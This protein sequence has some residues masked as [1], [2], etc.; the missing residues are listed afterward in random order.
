[1][2]W[3]RIMADDTKKND[4]QQVV[5]EKVQSDLNPAQAQLATT[6]LDSNGNI[7]II[8]HQQLRF[9]SHDIRIPLF[10]LSKSGEIRMT[11]KD[12]V[13]IESEVWLDIPNQ[14][15]YVMLSKM[16]GLNLSDLIGLTYNQK[17]GPEIAAFIASYLVPGE[18]L[19]DV[20]YSDIPEDDLE[21]RGLAA[22]TARALLMTDHATTFNNA[23]YSTLI[24]T[25]QILVNWGYQANILE[26]IPGAR[27]RYPLNNY[28]YKHPR[29][30]EDNTLNFLQVRI[31]Q[32]G[33]NCGAR[34]YAND[35]SAEF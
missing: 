18:I 2:L 29:R 16:T 30:N 33:L 1:M 25:D 24:E 19:L 20:D 27:S 13:E 31:G 35:R 11:M 5:V 15:R 12:V 23:T 7:S 6:L 32:T 34:Y 14:R 22:L 28:R 9:I 21:Y 17:M 4:E 26:G 10:N 3:F 8:L